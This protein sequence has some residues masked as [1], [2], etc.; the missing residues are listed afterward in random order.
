M[1]VSGTGKVQLREEIGLLEGEL[2]R[3]RLEAGWLREENQ[4]MEYVIGREKAIKAQKDRM[5]QRA[6]QGLGESMQEELEEMKYQAEQ[7]EG[8]VT[9][10]GFE[11]AL[12]ER[13]RITN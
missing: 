5:E 6:L 13:F 10:Y 3:A 2:R 1:A 12:N 9:P 7:I 11:Q 8:R 4:R